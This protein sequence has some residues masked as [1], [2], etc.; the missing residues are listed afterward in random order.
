M[1]KKNYRGGDF[2]NLLEERGI[3]G[4][5][6]SRALK[7]SLSLRLNQLLKK[8]K[9]TNPQMATRL[10]TSRAA[11]ERLLDASNSSV[12]L[13]TLGKAARALGHRVNIELAPVE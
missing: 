4:E 7:K 5:V 2:R 1:R 13:N 11:L 9:L 6:E 10:K 8:Q 12:T 3:L